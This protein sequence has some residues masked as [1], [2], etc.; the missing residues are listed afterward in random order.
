MSK[1]II[2]PLIFLLFLGIILFNPTG[3]IAISGAEEEVTTVTVGEGLI[4]QNGIIYENITIDVPISEA[5]ANSSSCC[6]GEADVYAKANSYGIRLSDNSNY[7]K[8]K[9]INLNTVASKATATT[10]IGYA[11]AIASAYGIHL[12]ESSENTFQYIDL[13]HISGQVSAST[14][15]GDTFSDVNTYGIYLNN[16]SGNSFEFINIKSNEF[17]ARNNSANNT[18]HYSKITDN[19]EYGIKNETG[20]FLEASLNWW[21]STDGPEVELNW[22]SFDYEGEGE[23]VLGKGPV[24]FSPWLLEN[25]DG[26][27]EEPGVQ[28]NSP[29]TILAKKVGPTPTTK[30]GNTGYLD[31]AIWGASNV[32]QKGRIIVPHGSY[33]LEEPISNNVELLSETGSTCNTYIKDVQNSEISLTGGSVKIG[34]LEETTPR[35]FVIKDKVIVNP[36]VDASSSHLNWNDLRNMVV[37]TGSGRLNAEYNWWGDLDPSDDVIGEVDYRPFLPE[38]PC[39]FSNYMEDH[40]IE[41][42]RAAIA[43]RMLAGSTCSEQLPAKLIA[44]YHIR[45]RE[46]EDL[47]DEFGCYSIRRALDR[48]KVDFKAFKAALR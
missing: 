17:G 24:A 44:N 11:E 39:S 25:P 31:M 4:S 20:N 42:P 12:Q 33:K 26:N 5:I 9:Y 13:D 34:K 18:I 30:S 47:I 27:P 32:S 21:G 8:F 37:N 45:P 41:N 28:L 29:F 48:E 6:G 2:S 7:N 16:S 23:L 14:D 22:K 1:N 43:D 19:S 15:K 35:G 3:S 40:N 38:E 10:E 36:G 46:A